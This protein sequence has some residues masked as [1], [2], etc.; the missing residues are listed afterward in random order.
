MTFGTITLANIELLARLSL[1]DYP[2]LS[3]EDISGRY[4]KMFVD[5]IS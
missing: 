1:D 4:D 3:L 2:G 5:S